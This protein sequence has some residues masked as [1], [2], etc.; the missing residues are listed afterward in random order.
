MIM[1][2]SIFAYALIVVPSKSYHFS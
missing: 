1:Q 2:V